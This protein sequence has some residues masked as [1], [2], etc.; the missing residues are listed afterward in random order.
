MDSNLRVVFSHDEAKALDRAEVS[1]LTREQRLQIGAELHAFWVR[2]Y[3][4]DARGLDR[5]VRV[6]QRSER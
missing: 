2:N 1:R 6:V 4:R 5:T 3:Y